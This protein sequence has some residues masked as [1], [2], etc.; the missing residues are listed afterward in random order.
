MKILTFFKYW[1]PPFLW[2]L[3]IFKFS[4]RM[5]PSTSDFYWNDFIVKK[6][7]HI[8]MYA[9]YAML[10]FR[11]FKGSGI[12]KKRSIV[13]AFVIS[14]A[15]AFSDEFHQ[16]FVPGRTARIYDLVFDTIGASVSLFTIWKL[17]PKTPRILKNL[18][19][20]LDLL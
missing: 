18:A 9:T 19:E 15:Y 7:A 11:A 17:S 14:L 8:V 5:L 6:S 16:S 20:K 10:I 3:L 1:L 2:S 12:D 13:L 4:S